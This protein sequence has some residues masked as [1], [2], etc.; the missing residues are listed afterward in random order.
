MRRFF[1]IAVLV[2]VVLFTATVGIGW[3]LLQDESFLK[4]QLASQTLKYTGRK[5]SLDGPVTLKLGRVTT[6]DANDVHFANPA[7]SEKPDMAAVG[8]LKISIDLSS[9]FADQIVFPALSLED[10]KVSLIRNDEG[11]PNWQMVPQYEPKSKPDPPPPPRDKLP[12]VFR[13]LQVQNCSLNLASLNLE[14]PLDFEFSSIA[15]QHLENDRWQSSIAG[16]LNDDLLSIDGWF[17]PF[18]ALLLGGPMAHDLNL[19]FGKITAESSGSVKDAKT[20]EGANLTTSIKGPDIGALLREFK[21]PA[22]SE[23]AFDY[24]LK[25]NTEGKLTKLDLNGDL[26][27]IDIRASGELDK[28]VNPGDGNVQF[29]IDGP[30]LG[31]LAKVFGVDGIVE[32]KFSHETHATFKK[33]AIHFNRAVLNTDSDHLEIG[34]HFNRGD[35]FAGTELT[36]RFQSDEAGRWTTVLGQPQQAL[37]PLDLD[38]SLSS[39]AAGLMSIK[40]N[41]TRGPDTLDVEGGLGHL[42]DELQPDLNIVFKSPDPS[43]LA[44]IAGLEAF[45]AAPLAIQGRFGMKG[46][47][48][49]LGKVKIDLAGDLAD[50]DGTINLADRYAGSKLNL[51]VDVKNAETLGLLFGREGLPDQPVKL[52]AELRPDGKGLA[53]KLTDGNLGDI[54]LELDGRI[55]D[56]EKPL[57]MDGDFD[58]DLPRLSDVTLLFPKI[59]LPNAPFSARGKL[60]SKE[61]AIQFNNVIINLAGD[62]ATING[63][64]KLEDRFAGSDLNAEMDIKSVAALGRLFDRDGLPDQPTRLTFEVKPSGKG[65]AFELHDSE[66]G[67]IKLDLQGT[68][69]DVAAPLSMDAEF[70]INLP[71]LS[72]VDFLVPK[73]KLPD[74]PFSARGQLHSRV[75]GVQIN[76]VLVN[77]AGDQATING[78][79]KLENHYAGS[80]LA[81]EL[82]VKSAAALGRLFGQDGLP[83]EPF[84]LTIGVKPNGKGMAF[85]IH[86]GDLRDLELDIQGQIADMDYPLVMD[87]S[88]DIQIPR[89]SEIAFLFPDKT[90]PEVPFTAKGRLK[91]Q[92]TRTQLDQVQLTLGGIKANVDGD[93]LSDNSFQLAVRASGPDASKL[94]GLAGTPL[95]AK[96]FSLHTS[97]SGSPSEFSLRNLNVDLGKSKISGDLAIGLG[98]VTRLKGKFTSPYLDAS[99]WYAG[100]ETEEEPAPTSKTPKKKWMFDETPVAIMDDHHLDIDLDLQIDKLF[101]GN[102]TFDEIKLELIISQRLLEIKP[103]TFKGEL[104]GRFYGEFSLNGTSG[105]PKLHLDMGGEDVRVGL[106]AAPEQDPSTYPPVDIEL[107]LDGA[108]ATNRELASSL[109]GRY[110]GYLGSGQ[111]ASAGLTLLFSDFLTQLVNALNPMAKDS[112]FTQL[113]C[114]VLAVDIVD[115]QVEFIPSIAHTSD[116][117]IFSQGAI[118]LKTEKIDISFNTKPRKGI[119]LTA[120]TLINSFIKVGGRLA[121]PAIELDPASTLVSG[122]LAVVTLGIS[123][124][125]KS[126]SD[127][128]LSSSDPCGDARKAIEKRDN[129][130]Q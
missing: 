30:N 88:F 41:V 10:C 1:L 116:I 70:N 45:P 12:V 9:L 125:A 22:F 11:E 94:D 67:A 115:G 120:G 80:D 130:A 4:K 19:S 2:L 32:D 102:T 43:H 24:Q 73:M 58:I 84:K 33:D 47:Q 59:K 20:W 111:L 23:G 122:G 117:T 27:S 121:S 62:R 82:D 38:A 48:I 15:M 100:K 55:P 57:M 129:A 17:M 128:F 37:G 21:L 106:A 93:L 105:T 31:A 40:A 124:L 39:D 86:D 81:A 16:S 26:G 66:L 103:F 108:G 64:L 83:D 89:L 101:L 44:A 35:G 13:D 52:G 8:H 60:E 3:Y 50:I 18:D 112:E 34:G 91:N 49:Q 97:L 114:A 85:E 119:G 79:L 7:W 54:Q 56:L 65:V 123:V 109:N 74:A 63:L 42:P 77:L 99:H 72:A 6:L 104:G 126:A 75:N 69:A 110:R 29:S 14:Y 46:K 25:L 118:D 96:T 95:P 107:F 113:D 36:I 5:L 28:L 127:R 90:L 51:Q 68:I 87:A 76:N 53:F 61:N 78:L 92:K 98:D 71:S